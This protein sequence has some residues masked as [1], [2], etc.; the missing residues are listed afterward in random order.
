MDKTVLAIVLGDSDNVRVACQGHQ[1]HQGRQ[2]MFAYGNN[3]AIVP[4]A[5][6]T[7]LLSRV[8]VVNDSRAA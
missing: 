6:V 5:I 7:L 8:S 4:L 3:Q 2:E 1:A